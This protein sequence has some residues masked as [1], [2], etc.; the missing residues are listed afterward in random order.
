MIVPSEDKK[1]FYLYND[2]VKHFD[3]MSDEDAG[4]L[5][6]TILHYVN[7]M[8]VG[9]LDGVAEIAFSFIQ[10]QLDRDRDKY[11]EICE[12]NRVNGK[13]GGRPKKQKPEGITETETELEMEPDKESEPEAFEKEKTETEKTARFLDGENAKPEKPKKP[14]T[15]TDK[16]T[17]TDINN[18]N[19][20]GSYTKDFEIFWEAYPRGKYAQ[21]PDKAG[22]YAKYKARLKDGWSPEELLTAAKNY[23]AEC[24]R[25]GTEERYIKLGKTFLS[26]KTP[27][28]DYLPK[29]KITGTRND[30]Y[31]EVDFAA[32][33]GEGATE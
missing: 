16:D 33:L 5:I 15:D 1:A 25:Y 8:E 11:Q 22:C 29:E 20:R 24:R 32:M 13:K 30:G 3:F 12:R 4:K 27:F 17:D 31:G 6:K 9:K 21:R 7:G 28:D 23:A 2:Y 14:D 26:E 18:K 10:C 19:I